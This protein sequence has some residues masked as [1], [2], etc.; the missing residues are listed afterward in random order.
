M[1]SKVSS[2]APVSDAIGHAIK[3]IPHEAK[4]F[5]FPPKLSSWGP[6]FDIKVRYLGGHDLDWESGRGLDTNKYSFRKST[7]RWKIK[8]FDVSK[9]RSEGDGTNQDALVIT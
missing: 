8:S 7:M 5:I 9:S 4:V 6:H 2:K 3:S 1:K